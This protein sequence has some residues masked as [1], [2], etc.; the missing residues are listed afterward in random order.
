VLS[1]EEEFALSH[2]QYGVNLEK[3]GYG[4]MSATQIAADETPTRS[5]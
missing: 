5:P 4:A 2:G 1:P 3:E